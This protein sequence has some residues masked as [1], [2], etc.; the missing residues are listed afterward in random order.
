MPRQSR[1]EHQIDHPTQNNDARHSIAPLSD[2]DRTAC[3]GWL[4]DMNFL[5]PGEQEDDVVW[6]KI[7]GNWIAYL[8]ATSDAP[9]AALAPHG[10]DGPEDRREQRRRFS[11]DRQRRMIIQSAFWNDLD[12]MEGMAERW[13]RAARAA[14]NSM[15]S[16][17]DS[18]DG[19]QGAFE[20]FAAVWDLGKRRQYQS[21]WMSLVG[22]ITYAHSR[23]TLES[24][25]MRLTESQIDD[26]LDI[27]QEVWQVDLR[28]IARRREKGGFEDVWVPIQQL[29]M[30]ALKNP[31]STPRNN[32]LVWWVAVLCRSAISDAGDSDEDIDDNDENK[33]FISRGR[34]YKNPMPMDVGFKERL[35]AIVHY[36]KVLVLNH[37]FLTWAAPTDWVMQ[38]QSRLNMVSI[39][40]IN[41]ER[42]SRPARLPGDGGP[43]YTTEAWQSMVA[44]ITEN[45]STL[46]GGKQKTAIYRLR[47]LANALQ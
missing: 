30:K 45:T 40:W 39:D 10:G 3:N 22:F 32:P 18:E 19:D 21:I 25:G 9:E 31:K 23:G 47:T 41:N 34:F 1:V 37:S 35:E 15:D 13:P 28:A 27:E 11:D 44:Y 24:M 33:D 5:R 46:L 38:V 29:L 14:L 42:G 43:V 36:S 12:A 4:Q 17:D 8:S 7:R 6:A 20:T 26:I 2:A 16:R